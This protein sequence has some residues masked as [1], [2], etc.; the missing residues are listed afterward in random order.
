M[1]AFTFG[2]FKV[3]SIAPAMAPGKQRTLKL[4]RT[5]LDRYSISDMT[6]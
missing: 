3:R 2:F 4:P 1:F 6:L 5:V